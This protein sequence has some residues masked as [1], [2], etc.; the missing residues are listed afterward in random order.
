[1]SIL[2]TKFREQQENIDL[3]PDKFFVTLL[4]TPTDKNKDNVSTNFT[5]LFYSKA[6]MM[7][8]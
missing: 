1:M 7:L 3:S 2:A 5:N 4:S 8:H 6:T